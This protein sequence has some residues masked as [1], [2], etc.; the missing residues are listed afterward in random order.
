MVS[1]AA[2]SDSSKR[3]RRSEMACSVL[4]Q[5]RALTASCSICQI[6]DAPENKADISIMLAPSGNG[7]VEASIFLMSGKWS[8]TPVEKY[9]RRTLL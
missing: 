5:S 2:F 4:T 9:E 8:G 3:E 6:P 1:I 7:C